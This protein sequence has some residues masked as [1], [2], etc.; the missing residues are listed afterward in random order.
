VLSTRRLNRVLLERQL[1]TRRRRMPPLAA[2]EHLIG[3]QAQS[4]RAGYVGLWTRLSGFRA[5]ELERLML[6]RQATRIAVM[7]ST[8]HLV[9]ADDCLELRSLTQPAVARTSRHTRLRQAAEVDE[10]ELERRGRALVEERPRTLAELG[11]LLQVRWPGCDP[12]ALAMGVRELVPLVQVPPRGLW[13][14]G[15]EARHTSAEHWLG[16]RAEQPSRA[17]LD[18]LLLR[19]LA[20][21]GPASVADAQA[22]TGLTGLRENFERLRHRLEVHRDDSDRELFDVPGAPLPTDRLRAPARLLPEFDNILLAHADRRRILADGDLSVLSL[23][24]GIKP[25][26]LADGFVAGSWKLSRARTSVTLELRPFQPLPGPAQGELIVEAQR[27]LAFAS[28]GL[29]GQVVFSRQ[30]SPRRHRCFGR[31]TRQPTGRSPGR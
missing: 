23:G 25:A 28:P 10:A 6:D 13:S 7:R 2:I 19:Y 22:F 14:G 20:A 27:F 29:D 1:L 4:P 8:I 18:R 21:Y 30:R 11:A 15:G 17:A 16:R 3:I 12:G 31:D 26:F 24:N 5:G 9:S